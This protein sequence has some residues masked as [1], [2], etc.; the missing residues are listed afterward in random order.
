MQRNLTPPGSKKGAFLFVTWSSVT[1]G[2]LRQIISSLQIV[3][4][5]PCNNWRRFYTQMSNAVDVLLM[6]DLLLLIKTTIRLVVVVFLSCRLLFL[7]VAPLIS[8][9]LFS[10]ASLTVQGTFPCSKGSN[11]FSQF[12]TVH[13]PDRYNPVSFALDKFKLQKKLGYFSFVERPSTLKMS[14]TLKINV[15]QCFVLSGT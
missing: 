5:K 12:V 6:F 10:H 13:I 7:A 3:K 9:P 11:T 14:L 4:H 1:N 8:S 15:R 2:A